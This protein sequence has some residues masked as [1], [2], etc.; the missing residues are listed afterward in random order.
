MTKT[1]YSIYQVRQRHTYGDI[2]IKDGSCVEAVPSVAWC[3]TH[4]LGWIKHYLRQTGGRLKLVEEVSG[5]EEKEV[6]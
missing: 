4:S 3:L 1:T 2:A 5:P 6:A